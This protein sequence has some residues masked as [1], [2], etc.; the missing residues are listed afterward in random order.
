M[1]Q[2]T[3]HPKYASWLHPGTPEFLGTHKVSYVVS[4]DNLE[5]REQ[6]RALCAFSPPQLCARASHGCLPSKGIPAHRE[7]IAVLF[8]RE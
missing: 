8:I 5:Q 7:G 2:I 4:Q 1:F 3:L 6:R